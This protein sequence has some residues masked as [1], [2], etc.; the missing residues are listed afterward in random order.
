MLWRCGHK[1]SEDMISSPKGSL[2]SWSTC[3]FYVQQQTLHAEDLKYSNLKR[4][5]HSFSTHK[6]EF[7]LGW[8]P[9][10]CTLVLDLRPSKR[11]VCVWLGFSG[12]L[13]WDDTLECFV[14]SKENKL[15]KMLFQ[16]II[17]KSYSK[18]Q[19]YSLWLNYTS[20]NSP[21]I[22]LHRDLGPTLQEITIN[23]FN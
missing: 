5:C 14:S 17:H 23:K 4:K 1:V 9:E 20:R 10:D 2:C 21:G 3:R 7:L 6:K 18:G 22:G 12:V 13:Q 15:K 19:G 11:G 8:R 16:F